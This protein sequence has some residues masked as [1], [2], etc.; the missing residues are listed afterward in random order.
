M[1]VHEK[2]GDFYIGNIFYLLH[3]LSHAL[4]TCSAEAFLRVGTLHPE[5]S[6]P[7]KGIDFYIGNIFYQLRQ[8]ALSDLL[9]KGLLDEN[10]IVHCTVYR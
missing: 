2:G 5:M 3:W 8:I 4:N 7:E 6:V 1:S 9:H 10:V